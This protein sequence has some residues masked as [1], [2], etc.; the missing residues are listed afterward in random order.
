[1]L[2]ATMLRRGSAYMY[3]NT[4]WILVERVFVDAARG[5]ALQFGGSGQREDGEVGQVEHGEDAVAEDQQ[6]VEGGACP[7]KGHR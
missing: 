6:P 1:M 7:Q 3:L 2:H 5:D 4:K